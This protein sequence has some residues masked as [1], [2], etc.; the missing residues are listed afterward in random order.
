MS[1]TKI[2][3]TKVYTGRG[4]GYI[5]CITPS[6]TLKDILRHVFYECGD[7]QDFMYLAEEVFQEECEVLNNAPEFGN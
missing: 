3:L 2:H 5:W 6:H 4:D 7:P 1:E